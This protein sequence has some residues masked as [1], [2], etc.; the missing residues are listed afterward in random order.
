APGGI[1]AVD[2]KGSLQLM[3]ATFRNLTASEKEKYRISGAMVTAT[4]SGILSRNTPIRP[5]FVI[6][7]LNGSEI[8]KVSDLQEALMMASGDRIEIGGM[9][10]GKSGM[11]YYGF[12]YDETGDGL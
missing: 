7:R 4:G 1:A 5:G 11:Y 12:P 3:G 6:T 2:A 9:Y 8:N 10:P